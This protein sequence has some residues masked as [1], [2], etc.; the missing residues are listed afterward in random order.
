VDADGELDLTHGK[1]PSWRLGTRASWSG[2]ILILMRFYSEYGGSKVEST[3][4]FYAT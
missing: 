3:K 4:A 1:D 2:R